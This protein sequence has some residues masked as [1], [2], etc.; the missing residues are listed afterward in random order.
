MNKRSSNFG[1]TLIELLVVVAI[2][3]I[4]GGIGFANYFNVQQKSQMN[5]MAES[6]VADMRATMARA[7]ADEGVQQWG[8]HFDNTI[9][10]RNFYA[11]W[12]G[13]TYASGT[14]VNEVSL[15]TAGIKFTNPASGTSTNLT[16]TKP[17]G[18]PLASTTIV[19]APVASSTSNGPRTII[20][21]TNGTITY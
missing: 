2:L 16:F 13:P 19:I 9:A 11:I 1:F 5:T 3:A 10:S 12:Y 4:L 8:M 20:I 6:I 15:S 17:Y 14:V 7:A 21:D 18:Q